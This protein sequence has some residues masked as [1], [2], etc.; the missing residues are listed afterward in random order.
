MHTLDIGRV[1][2]YHDEQPQEQYF[3]NGL[4]LGFDGFV[5]KITNQRKK[6]LGGS[7]WTY[8]FSVCAAVFG[9]SAKQMTLASPD[10]TVQ[11][12]IFTISVGNGCY[13]GGGLKQTPK[14]VP[15]DGLFHIT[16]I[17]R[18]NLWKII[19]GL[20]QLLND[21]LDMH[22]LA[23]TFVTDTFLIESEK[24]VLTEVDGVLLPL[25]TKFKVDNLHAALKMMV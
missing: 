13:S 5:G 14:A 11:E 25:G 12:N 3:I 21:Q 17:Q 10:K 1:T 9:Y 4:G 2:I 22:P 8:R 16:A 6:F 7:A 24:P 20:K 19:I 18:P 15:T 23:H